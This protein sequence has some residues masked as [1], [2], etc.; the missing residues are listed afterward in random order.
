MIGAVNL[1]SSNRNPVVPEFESKSRA[2][3]REGIGSGGWYLPGSSHTSWQSLHREPQLPELAT[4]G[5]APPQ[6]GL[7]RGA[8]AEGHQPRSPAH[9]AVGS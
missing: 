9:L 7:V 5:P 4:S 2:D 8:L 3:C 1:K 6:A